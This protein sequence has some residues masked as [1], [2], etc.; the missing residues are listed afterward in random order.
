MRRIF[1]ILLL[2][3]APLLAW[4]HTE[5]KP[6]PA[7]KAFQFSATAKDNQTAVMFFKIAPGYYLY[8]DKFAFTPAEPGSAV[9]ATPMLPPGKQKFNPTVGN[10]TALEG[11]LQFALPVLSHKKNMLPLKVH[12]QGCSSEGFCYPPITKIIDIDLGGN[13]GTVVKPIAVDI[14]AAQPE[15]L[16]DSTDRITRI[17]S[18]SNIGWVI[19]AFFGFGVLISLT[20]CILPMIPILSSIIIGQSKHGQLSHLRSFMLSLAY[21]LGMAITY[22]I[23]GMIFGYLGSNIQAALQI[24]WV[25][26]VF[27]VVFVLL[28]LSMFG[29]YD[30]QIPAKLQTKLH[31]SSDK[32]RRGS[33][34]GVGLMGAISSLVMSPCVTPPLVGALGFIS[35][36]GNALTGGIALFA[37]GIGMGVPLLV[38]GATSAKLLP[39]SGPWMNAIKKVLGV[40][41]LAVA[42]TLL[43]RIIPDWLNMV[44]WMLLTFGC[45]YALGAFKTADGITQ[46]IGKALGV[47][48]F[49]YGIILLIGLYQGNTNPLRPI[50]QNRLTS[51]P[52]DQFIRITTTEQLQQQLAKA[53]TSKKPVM[54]D[55][56]ADWCI[57]CKQMTAYTFTNPQVQ[58][59]LQ[60]YT[61]I[62]VDV[63]ANNAQS[64]QLQQR[65]GVIAPPTLIFI[66]PSGQIEHSQSVVGEINAE[67]L[68]KHL[69][70]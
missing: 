3:L 11:N 28:A 17:L 40:M 2:F 22:A 45:A 67:D 35:R 69:A 64:K 70:Q 34:I 63:T 59:A 51:Q 65:Y 30:I 44:L 55:F 36:T 23:A 29:Y 18:N 32:Q 49:I 57:A 4:S 37:L 48:L 58:Q 20:P 25:I 9:I 39:K 50:Q 60:K 12:Y 38:I 24:P 15:H 13:Y 43:S 8:R 10:Y 6:L 14:P 62:K 61:L 53:K 42:I 52:A 66:S 54:L 1:Y 46:R 31:H 47:I 21:V 7:D 56:Y 41:L 68:L 33:Y 26:I 16:S 27:T 19:L 5:I